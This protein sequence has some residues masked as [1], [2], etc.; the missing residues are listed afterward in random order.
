VNAADDRRFSFDFWPLPR[1]I[2]SQNSATRTADSAPTI[3]QFKLKMTNIPH[4]FSLD[5]QTGTAET[6]VASEIPSRLPHLR[7]TSSLKL[8]LARGAL[9]LPDRN[10]SR[11]ISMSKN[12]EVLIEFFLV[13][14]SLPRVPVPRPPLSTLESGHCQ[15]IGRFLFPIQ[16]GLPLIMSKKTTISH[17][18]S[19]IPSVPPD[20]ISTKRTV[21][22]TG[23]RH[24]LRANRPLKPSSP[25]VLSNSFPHLSKIKALI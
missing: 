21:L 7:A 25:C 5:A 16:P 2:S 24:F 10:R 13:P 6:V 22:R 23:W 1:P 4:T 18:V 8:P 9:K 20:H 15:M 17:Q 19:I 14:L 12:L 3:A 11:I